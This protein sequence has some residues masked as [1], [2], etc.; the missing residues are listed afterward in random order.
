[1]STAGSTVGGMDLL[2]VV[3]H[4]LGHKLG[5]E[6][7]CDSLSVMAPILDAGSRALTTKRPR[8]AIQHGR[9]LADGSSWLLH[10]GG[11]SARS[12]NRRKTSS[13]SIPVTDSSPR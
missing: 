3:A 11:G 12:E 1:M 7:S 9:D 6:H 4:E 13:R 10:V 8:N 2:S 5:L